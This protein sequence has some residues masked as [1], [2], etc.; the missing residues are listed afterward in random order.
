MILLSDKF[1]VALKC[2]GITRGAGLQLGGKRGVQAHAG[3]PRVGAVQHLPK[4]TLVQ[5]GARRLA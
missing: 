4:D 2:D 1:D 3:S 5:R